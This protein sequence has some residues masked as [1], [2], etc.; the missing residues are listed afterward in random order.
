MTQ[1]VALREEVKIVW[2][3]CG[4]AFL[5]DLKG[6]TFAVSAE[7]ATRLHNIVLPRGELDEQNEPNDIHAQLAAAGLLQTENGRC[8]R[9]PFLNY[10][11]MIIARVA[12][13][14]PL[15]T[16]LLVACSYMLFRC[17]CW[18]DVACIWTECFYKASGRSQRRSLLHLG[19]KV[20]QAI[21][22]SVLPVRCKERALLAFALASREGHSPDLVVGCAQP[23]LDLH[24]WTEVSGH[25]I[26][27]D[28]ERCKELTE[29]Q[30]LRG[31]RLGEVQ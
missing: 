8:S 31:N 11:V 21:E 9:Q 22:G 14:V 30:R 6:D 13:A 12:C 2:R 5:I 19:T 24:C 7:E 20:Q 10:S 25:V 15:P 1:A 27:D 29:I 28:P 16:A 4:G 26:G 17:F 3:D 18:H 23:C